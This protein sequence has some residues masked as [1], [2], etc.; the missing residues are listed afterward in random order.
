MAEKAF[1][2]LKLGQ[3]VAED[4]RLRVLLILRAD[5]TCGRCNELLIAKL[6]NLKYGHS[7]SRDLLRVDLMWLHES[8]LCEITMQDIWI[9]EISQR[10]CDVADGNAFVPGIARRSSEL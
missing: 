3:V 6:L 2:S 10:G 8:L 5:V 4:R 9:A 7:V 1:L